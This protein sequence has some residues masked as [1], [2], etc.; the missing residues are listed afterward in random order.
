MQDEIKNSIGF[1]N[2]LK[3]KIKELNLNFD[4]IEKQINIFHKNIVEGLQI[5]D[6]GSYKNIVEELQIDNEKNVKELQSD[7]GNNIKELQSDN[8][9]NIEKYNL[10]DIFLT[11]CVE[12]NLEKIKKF[13][14]NNKQNNLDLDKTF[15]VL[16]KF[17]DLDIIKWLYSFYKPNLK[18]L[19]DAFIISSNEFKLDFVKWLYP[20]ISDK[21][22][23]HNEINN[24][25]SKAVCNNNINM[26]KW[27][28]YSCDIKPNIYIDNGDLFIT[29]CINGNIEIVKWLKYLCNDIFE[30]KLSCRKSIINKNSVDGIIDGVVDFKMA[31][32]YKQKNFKKLIL[33]LNFKER[34]FDLIGSCLTC[35]SNNIEITTPCNHSFCLDCFLRWYTIDIKDNCYKCNEFL[36]PNEC[37]I[38]KSITL[39]DD[40]IMQNDTN[41]NNNQIEI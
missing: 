35:Y 9:N 41:N 21:T 1:E 20:I 37:F 4:K 28:Y 29:A 32:L 40:S 23:I 33:I 24:L 14:E 2:I 10:Q 15:K 36:I 31:E 22:I 25:F 3:D 11:Y 5:N 12:G 17:G 19:N 39:K 6:K 26:A 27:C 30:Y 13:Y 18:I 8:G 16:S 38:K 34:E 7:N